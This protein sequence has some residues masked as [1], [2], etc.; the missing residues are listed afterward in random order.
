MDDVEL[1]SFSVKEINK[2]KINFV[3]YMYYNGVGVGGFGV[4][5][6]R[7]MTYVI[8]NSEKGR[9]LRKGPVQIC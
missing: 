1:L 8:Q 6:G 9:F 3:Y 7:G 2:S 4:R 5:V